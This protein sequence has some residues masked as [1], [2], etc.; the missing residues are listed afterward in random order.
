MYML[1][2]HMHFPPSTKP[3]AQDATYPHHT[4]VWL[5]TIVGY[6][7]LRL[8]LRNWFGYFC[9]TSD[10]IRPYGM[11]LY[12]LALLQPS[13]RDGALGESISRQRGKQSSVCVQAI[14]TDETMLFRSGTDLVQ[15]NKQTTVKT[16]FVAYTLLTMCG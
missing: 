8:L 2:M 10:T 14:L 15:K 1:C 13:V 4:C 7:P 11:C 6:A 3:S 9:R 5:A 16:L 12:L